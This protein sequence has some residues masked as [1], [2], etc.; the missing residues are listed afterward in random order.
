MKD[1]LL[2]TRPGCHLCDD[3]RAAVSTAASA[4]G[5]AVTERNVDDD[6]ELRAEYGDLVP[7]VLIDGIVHG[8][9]RIDAAELQLALQP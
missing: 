4:T 8:Y 3:A 7:V 9:F 6:R 2:L 1:L 5:T